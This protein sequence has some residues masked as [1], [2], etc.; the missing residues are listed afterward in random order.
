MGDEV[1]QF[2]QNFWFDDFIIIHDGTLIV[3]VYTV[4]EQ[5]ASVGRLEPI[6]TS[7]KR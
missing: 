3:V 1:P 4:F 5:T 7:P 2:E 6:I